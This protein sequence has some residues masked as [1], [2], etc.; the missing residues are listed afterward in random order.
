MRIAVLGVG[1]VGG[2]FGGR[3]AEAGHD[4]AFIARGSQ[5]AALRE[6]GLRIESPAGDVML[7]RVTVGHEPGADGFDLVL[8]GVKA[9]QV[10]EVAG[11]VADL[12]REDGL[13]LPL[14]NGVEAAGQLARAV[15]SA[16][17][18]GGVCR[19]VVY[20][21]AP[22]LVRHAGV[23][24]R[25]EVGELDGVPGPRAARVLEAFSGA[26]GV[27]VVAVADIQ[28]ALWE[29]FLLIAPV[30]AVGAVTRQPVGVYRSVAETRRLLEAAM[31]EV[32]A[33]ARARGVELGAD[34]VARNL[35]YID[36]LPADATASMQRDLAEG[37]P[38]ELEAQTGAVLRLGREC[39]VP[40]PASAFLYA[41]LL[42]AEL[43]ARRGGRQVNATE[44]AGPEGTPGQRAPER[45]AGSRTP[46]WSSRTP[47]PSRSRRRRRR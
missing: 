8:L 10:P 4:V 34:A 19:I 32:A 2:Y 18:L 40:T 44:A 43:E 16:R 21:V 15:G 35:S 33:V 27:E 39:G 6:R 20:V 30:S 3:L 26:V 11:K 17:V 41:A 46:G 9:W 12:L 25:I 28:R 24:P 7:P 37:R 42:P 45:T 14:Q 1:G 36:K 22:G 29:K 23:R 31:Q 47:A 5:A 38:S 13:V